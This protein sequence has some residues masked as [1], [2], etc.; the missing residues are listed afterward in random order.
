MQYFLFKNVLTK[1]DASS[2]FD[3]SHIV[4]GRE[5]CYMINSTAF[6]KAVERSG[7]T[8]YRI[9]EI[10]GVPFI[11]LEMKSRNVTEFLASEIE[12]FCLVV[13]VTTRNEKEKIFFA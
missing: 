7:M 3:L 8:M 13:G 4:T 2:M 6:I 5:E 1:C 10:M 12:S 9:A 11:S